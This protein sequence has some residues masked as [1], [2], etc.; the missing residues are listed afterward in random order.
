MACMEWQREDMRGHLGSGRLQLRQ[1]RRQPRCTPPM[2]TGPMHSPFYQGL[3]GSS[4]KAYKAPTAQEQFEASLPQR[5]SGVVFPVKPATVRGLRPG[6]RPWQEQ[7][8]AFRQACVQG[9]EVEHVSRV[10]R[11][12]QMELMAKKHA[13][14]SSSSSF[15]IWTGR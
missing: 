9:G 3:A 11:G 15:G 12:M 14:Q 13:G 7:L 1:L 8:R 4:Y 2:H 5:T 6:L 10:S